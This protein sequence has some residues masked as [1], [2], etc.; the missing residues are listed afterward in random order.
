MAKKLKDYYGIDTAQLW[1]EKISSLY[2]EFDSYGFMSHVKKEINDKE[3]LARQDVFVDA[4]DKVS[5]HRLQK[6][7]R[8]ILSVT[9]A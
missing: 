2:P 6:E 3:F 4:F 1:A 9:W 8:N 5:W 7:Y